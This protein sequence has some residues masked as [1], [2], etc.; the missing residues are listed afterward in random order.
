MKRCHYIRLT[1]ITSSNNNADLLRDVFI[2][3]RCA[4]KGGKKHL[5]CNKVFHRFAGFVTSALHSTVELFVPD[6]QKTDL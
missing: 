1:F 5:T 2:A 4:R 6:T 3:R